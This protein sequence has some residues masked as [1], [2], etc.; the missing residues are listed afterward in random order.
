MLIP[1]RSIL[2]HGGTGENGPDG[3]VQGSILDDCAPWSSLL[4]AFQRS[5]L[6]CSQG[7]WS[8]HILKYLF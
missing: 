6:A 4:R 1:C 2:G 8:T 3:G 7:A 5:R